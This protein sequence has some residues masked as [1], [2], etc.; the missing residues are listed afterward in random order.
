MSDEAYELNMVNY[1]MNE[2]GF[3]SKSGVY[4]SLF[5]IL[6]LWN[7]NNIPINSI[8]LEV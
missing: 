8:Y 3:S 7:A 1:F 4:A 5:H 2:I 6:A